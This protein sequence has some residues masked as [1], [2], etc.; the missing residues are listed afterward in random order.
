ML[1]EWCE[2][3]AFSLIIWA[4]FTVEIWWIKYEK[5]F[6]W[7]NSHLNIVVC[8]HCLLYMKNESPLFS[9]N[10]L[11]IALR[12][13]VPFIVHYYRI[14][15]I[16][17]YCPLIRW[18]SIDLALVFSFAICFLLLYSSRFF[19]CVC[20]GVS[21][22]L[23]S[24]CRKSIVRL[25]TRH[26]WSNHHQQWH[27]QKFIKTF[28]FTISFDNNASFGSRLSDVGVNVGLGVCEWFYIYIRAS[29]EHVKFM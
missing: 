9:S 28:L 7:I 24:F 16:L 2:I 8:R 5:S 12:N 14:L 20:I 17:L 27:E 21:S 25:W 18:C 23:I 3:L 29:D 11:T 1:I 15:F 6:T 10:T 4:L 13:A 19:V 22:M 26:C